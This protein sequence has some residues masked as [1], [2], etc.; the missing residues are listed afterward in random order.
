MSYAGRKLAER[1]ELLSLDQAI[2]GGAQ[3]I[4]RL[5]KLPRA[6]L[7]LFEQSSAINGDDCLIC[8]R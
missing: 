4:E 6:R 7:H 5:R 3:I 2:L 1:R 8:E